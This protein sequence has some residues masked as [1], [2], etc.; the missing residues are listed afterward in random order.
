MIRFGETTREQAEEFCAHVVA[1]EPYRLRDLAERMRATG[2]PVARIRSAR[3]RNRYGSRA[4]TC[5]QNSSACSRVVSPNLI[6][7]PHVGRWMYTVIPASR[8]RCRT[9]A[10]GPIFPVV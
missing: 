2:P 7:R 6:I 8:S 3:S 4:T 1:R 9:V 10:D 5:A